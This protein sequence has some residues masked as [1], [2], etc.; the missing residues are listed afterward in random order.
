MTE[1]KQFYKK[2]SGPRAHDVSITLVPFSLV[3]D[4]F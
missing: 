3:L 4:L 2:K 1:I